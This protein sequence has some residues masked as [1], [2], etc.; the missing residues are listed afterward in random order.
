MPIISNISVLVITKGQCPL[1]EETLKSLA[2]FKEIHVCHS[3]VSEDETSIERISR[4]YK[5]SYSVFYWNG[6]Y[7]KKRQWCLDNLHFQNDWIFMIDADEVASQELIT[8]MS[9][10][11]M[12]GYAGFFVKG[13]YVLEGKLMRHGFSNNK[14]CLL[15]RKKMAF[16]VVNDLDAC[17]MGEVEGHYQPILIDPIAS[18]GRMKSAVHHYVANESNQWSKK[19]ESYAKWE[20]FM[21][22]RKQH[23]IDPIPLRNFLKGVVRNCPFSPSLAFAHSLIFRQGWR[24]GKLG[25]KW[26]KMRYYYYKEIRKNI[27]K[28]YSN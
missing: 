10:L 24:C 17:G 15:H 20:A 28:Y 3:P 4:K 12:D 18:I 6:Q 21:V 8:E 11:D 9:G 7:P 2:S 1:L 26:S 5:A 22:A 16:P 13:L 14:L 25:L 23:P 27:K 19:H